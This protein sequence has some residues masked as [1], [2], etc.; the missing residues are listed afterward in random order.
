VDDLERNPAE[1]R[2]VELQI[3]DMPTYV[4]D[5]LAEMRKILVTASDCSEVCGGCRRGTR[6]RVSSSR[7]TNQT[8][9]PSTHLD[10]IAWPILRVSTPRARGR[11]ALSPALT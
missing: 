6:E 2:V 9:V 4:D 1:C 11:F 10:A 8:R 7:S 5:V 3:G